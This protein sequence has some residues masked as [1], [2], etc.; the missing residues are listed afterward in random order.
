VEAVAGAAGRAPEQTSF[1][2]EWELVRQLSDAYP[3]DPGVVLSLLLNRVTLAQ[4]QAMFLKAGSIHAYLRGVGVE[5]MTSSDNVLRGGLTS[6][7]VD[8]AALL[9][10]VR[11][12]QQ[13]ARIITP[14][15]PVEGIGVYRTDGDEFV[16]ARIDLGD[17]GYTH[18]Y[19]LTGP[20]RAAFALTGPAIALALSGAVTVAGATGSASLG[21]GDAVFL[22]PDEQEVLFTGSGTVVVATTP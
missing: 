17:A 8:P 9:E 6:K 2:R 16:L 15:Q 14:D 19:R 5:L 3:G 1:G 20:D 18:G 21:R 12:E 4:G 11:F 7:H 10:V 22:S 13:P